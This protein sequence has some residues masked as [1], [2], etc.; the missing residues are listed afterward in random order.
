[1]LWDF[2]QYL[3]WE[4]WSRGTRSKQRGHE[5]TSR[6]QR[7]Y[8]SLIESRVGDNDGLVST[9][10]ISV[11]FLRFWRLFWSFSR[12]FWGLFRQRFS[13]DKQRF[14]GLKRRFLLVLIVT[15]VPIGGNFC[16]LGREQIFPSMVA[17]RVIVLP[18][19]PALPTLRKHYPY[20][21]KIPTG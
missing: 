12:L 1:M 6:G 14:W 3:K 13:C 21:R 15:I 5:I 16:G 9:F 20:M 19:L 2:R 17:K 11:S 18:T 7:E 8:C 4:C 10:G